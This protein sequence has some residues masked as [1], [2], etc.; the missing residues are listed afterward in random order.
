MYLTRPDTDNSNGIPQGS[1][2]DVGS[3][4]VLLT[5]TEGPIEANE[6]T[7]AVLQHL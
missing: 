2:W 1:L 7:E 6:Y 3:H 5:K 4:P